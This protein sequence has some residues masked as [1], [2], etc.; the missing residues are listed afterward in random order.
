MSSTPQKLLHDASF[1]ILIPGAPQTRPYTIDADA[2]ATQAMTDFRS[3]PVVTTHFDSSI[4]DALNQMK[5]SGARFAFVLGA[6]RRLVGSI[7]SYDIQGEKPVQY[8]VSVGCTETTCAWRDVQVENIMEPVESWHVLEFSEVSQLKV[9]E[10][11][12]LVAESRR[13]YVVVVEQAAEE[14]LRQIRGLFS[15]ARLQML[16]GKGDSAAVGTSPHASKLAHVA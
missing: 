6:D 1:P 7:T 2:P 16:L 5:L 4:D 13:R 8:M 9:A 14:P 15:A 10:V 12:R 3:A 11:A